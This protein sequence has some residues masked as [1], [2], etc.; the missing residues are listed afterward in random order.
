MI[1]YLSPIQSPML[2][3]AIYIRKVLGFKGKLAALSPC[4]AKIDEFRE[5]GLV[6]YNVT[7]DHLKKYFD[8]KGVN[9]PQVKIYSEFEFDE[10]P[11]MEGAIYSKPGG[12]M[13]NLLIHKP[14]MKVITSEGVDRL[15]SD[16]EIYL[17][18][19]EQK[20]PVVFDVLNCETG[21]NG[22]P[23]TGVNYHRFVMNDI[24][25]DVEH[26]A[27]KSRKENVTKKGMDKQFAMFDKQLEL[28]D[29]IRVYQPH[30]VNSV[31]VSE[32]DI[33]KSF[34][35]LGKT[36]EVE[37]H[38]DCHSCGYKSCREMAI[39]L[40]RGINEKENCHQYVM[41]TI[42][43]ERQ[44]VNSINQRVLT[45]NEE[46][47]EVFVELEHSI[48]NVKEEADKIRESGQKSSDEMVRV[49]DHMNQLNQ[50]NE[51]IADA[52][53]N[54]NQSVE[55]Y[56]D[57][58]KDVESIA[59]KINLL[60]LNAAIE[61]A[62]AGE[63]GKGFAVVAANI[64]NLSENSRDSV[65]SAKENDEAI[66]CAIEEINEVLY[67]FEAT[68]HELLGAVN[69]TIGNVNQASDNSMGIQQS[70][71]VVSQIAR[72]VHEVIQSTSN[73]LKP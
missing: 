53:Q 28:N 25:H 18:Q 19:D 13:T 50:L 46:L 14:D 69:S 56:N 62:R 47:M 48:Q 10:Q 23:A 26:Y 44:Q 21:C 27:R 66:H 63:A 65:G 60:S 71:A 2:C 57:M 43:Q 5:T 34:R 35:V 54:I 15:Y 38:F 7:M 52:V 37:K 51:N 58:T 3:S 59:G 64:K 30:T 40:A 36:T 45:M 67:S 17:E 33:E 31:E 29:F 22:G 72:Q 12:L 24:M 42:R 6:D 8:E 32:T 49:A 11:G 70:M 9:L 73:I 55:K 41:N 39:A 4:I 16:L 20:L 61:A 1:P 68:I